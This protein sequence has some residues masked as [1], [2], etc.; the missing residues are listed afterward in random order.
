MACSPLR[1]LDP[2][3]PWSRGDT[4]A[5]GSS[6]RIRAGDSAQSPKERTAPCGL[7]AF[8]VG[9]MR[10]VSPVAVIT[11]TQ[12]WSGIRTLR[13]VDFPESPDPRSRTCTAHDGIRVTCVKA[14]EV[15][16]P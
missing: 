15:Y 14:C 13:T 16:E 6:Y 4:V 10:L 8:A 9:F 2:Y 7:G 1:F 3:P 5:R 11:I 12:M